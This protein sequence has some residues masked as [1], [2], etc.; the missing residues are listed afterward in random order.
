MLLALSI[1]TPL[2]R[3][4][5]RA[6]EDDM[7]TSRSRLAGLVT[8]SALATVAAADELPIAPQIYALTQDLESIQK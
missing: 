5:G 6:K 1:A 4:G 7:T 2:E 8:V 3:E